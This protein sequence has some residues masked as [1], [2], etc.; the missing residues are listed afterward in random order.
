MKLMLECC[1][2]VTSVMIKKWNHA[3]TIGISCAFTKGMIDAV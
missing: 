1:A 2:A 3:L